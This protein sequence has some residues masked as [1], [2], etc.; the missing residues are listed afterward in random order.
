MHTLMYIMDRLETADAVVGS[1]KEMNVGHD[2][3]RVFSKDE[4][5][6]SRHH[7]HDATLFDKTDLLHTGERGAL[8]GGVLGILFA[9]GL[10]LSQP[11]GTPV[12]WSAFLAASAIIG[13]FGAWAGGMVGIG[14]TEPC[15]R[16]ARTHV[17]G[18]GHA[19]E[20][21]VRRVV[22][23]TAAAGRRYLRMVG[24]RQHGRGRDLEGSRRK[25]QRVAP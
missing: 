3:Y 22:V 13:F 25:S 24:R 8:I 9:L 23:V 10:I 4:D 21:E 6:I 14:R 2:A 1:L 19:L 16:G 18:R 20:R 17:D 15:R 7:L 12:G 5:G 11:F